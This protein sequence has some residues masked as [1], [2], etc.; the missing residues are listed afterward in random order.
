MKSWLLP[1][2]LLAPLCSQ[3]ASTPKEIK[4]RFSQFK[5]GDKTI[6]LDDVTYAN[7]SKMKVIENGFVV[8]KRKNV[9][10]Y[11]SNTLFLLGNDITVNIKA[12]IESKAGKTGFRNQFKQAMI[13]VDG[14]DDPTRASEKAK[15]IQSFED[16]ISDKNNETP[17]SSVALTDKGYIITQ[18]ESHS[19]TI[20]EC[21]VTPYKKPENNK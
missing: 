2:L 7:N 17:Y 4:A 18:M 14:M 8:S 15:I 11:Q 16:V 19:T 20:S 13:R 9:L 6:C 5:V 3:A 12:V 10:V 21:Y 1:L